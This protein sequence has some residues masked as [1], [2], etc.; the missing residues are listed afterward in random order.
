MQNFRYYTKGAVGEHLLNF[1]CEAER[2]RQM[3]PELRRFAFREIQFKFLTKGS[4]YEIPD[5]IKQCIYYGECTG[6]Q[7]ISK[8]LAIFTENV[9]VDA[10]NCVIEKLCGYWVPKYVLHKCCGMSTFYHQRDLSEPIETKRSRK[11]TMEDNM[12]QSVENYVKNKKGKNCLSS[13]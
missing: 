9:F 5:A 4:A 8:H 6:V 1:W 2:F 11:N 13:T 12:T 10:Q 7:M 3:K